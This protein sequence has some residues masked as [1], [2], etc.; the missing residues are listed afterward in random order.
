MKNEY[1]IDGDTAIL[2]VSYKGQTF[3]CLIDTEDLVKIDFGTTWFPWYCKHGDRFY[4]RTTKQ[5]NG[6]KKVI[7]LHRLIMNLDDNSL[8]VDHINHNTLDNRK[9]NLKV[10]TEIENQQNR[11]GATKASASGIRGVGIDPSTGRWRARLT[12][13]K[14]QIYLGL[15]DSKEQAE[16]KVISARKEM[17]ANDNPLYECF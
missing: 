15:F 2:F 9:K 11:N 1:R 14:K 8:V 13:N 3:N 12:V 10:V 5:I 4:V 7:S 16:Q 6:I 17:M